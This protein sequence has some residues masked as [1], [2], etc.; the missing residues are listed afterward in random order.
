MLCWEAMDT[1]PSYRILRNPVYA[2]ALQF[3]AKYRALEAAEARHRRVLD[4]DE[5]DAAK[6]AMHR[7]QTAARGAAEAAA[8]AADV[9]HA[10]YKRSRNMRGA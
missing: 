1:L 7:A 3:S 10:A 8:L 2:K 6:S 5:K 9:A 4:D